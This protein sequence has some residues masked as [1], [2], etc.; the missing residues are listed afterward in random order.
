MLKTL[1]EEVG[2]TKFVVGRDGP[3]SAGLAKTRR[4]GSSGEVTRTETFPGYSSGQSI[5]NRSSS[6]ADT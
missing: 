5:R 2:W 6:K 3:H 4:L 1:T